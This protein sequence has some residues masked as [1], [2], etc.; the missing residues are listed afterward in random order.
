MERLELILGFNFLGESEEN[1]KYLG[2]LIINIPNGL[3]YL[4]LHLSMSNLGD[5]F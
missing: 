1:L 5:N 3:K 4:D 2:N